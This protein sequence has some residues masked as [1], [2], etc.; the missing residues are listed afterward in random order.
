MITRIASFLLLLYAIGFVL[1]ALTL[2]AGAKDGEEPT[3]LSS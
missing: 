2:E 3:R 1:F